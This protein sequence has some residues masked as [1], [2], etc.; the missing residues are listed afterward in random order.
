[1]KSG[2]FAKHSFDSR[3]LWPVLVFVSYFVSA[4]LGLTYALIGQTVTLMWPPSGIAL[5]AILLGGFRIWPSIAL[6][7]L[8]ANVFIEHLTD[9]SVAII[10]VG[11]TLEPMIGAALLKRQQ[12]FSIALDKTSDVLHLLILAASGSTMIGAAFG[13]LALYVNG[14][15]DAHG[16][17]VTCLTWWLGDGMG[18]L[19]VSPLIL[20][21]F[22]KSR[23]VVFWPWS[24]R[25][26]EA[27]IFLL[28]VIVT[29]H[30]LFKRPELA[31]LGYFQTSLSMFPFAIWSALRFGSV[32]AAGT[33]LL[34]SSLAIHGTVNGTGPFALDS[35]LSSLMLWCLFADLIAITGLILAAVDGGRMKALTALKTSN[36]TLD[37]QVKER[38]SELL[39]A[40][41][42]LYA[43][44]EE[45]NRLQFEMN[46]ISEERQKIIG[47]ELHDGLGQQLTG[48][49]FM[50]ASLSEQLKAQTRPEA[51]AMENIGQLLDEALTGLRSL[52]RGLYPTALETGGLCSALQ[53]LA[54]YAQS[55][56]VRCAFNS[57]TDALDID[58]T[59][60]L[61]L[62]RIGQEAVCNAIRH[63]R[64]QYI[65][66]CLLKRNGHYRLTI[67]DDGSGFLET[68]TSQPASLGIRS[69]RS[70]ANLIGAN[71]EFN[72][73]AGGGMSIIVTGPNKPSPAGKLYGR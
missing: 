51:V 54:E 9:V 1:M 59:S 67:A 40:N 3:N 26:L 63:G 15:I 47:Q 44:L 66:I 13:G 49:A 37:K 4:K 56:G 57:N 71:I 38:T 70:R 23:S 29:G 6:G 32:G 50:V 48:I 31:G 64:P 61:N 19:V 53:Y 11:D 20:T 10:T 34:V 7:A 22:S 62:Y 5:A 30:A 58:K 12:D 69:M 65:D 45:R 43:T 28:M 60:A 2:Y 16:I 72:N 52:S 14:E 8:A 39:D 33:A 68:A 21:F 73:N 18:V 35:K 41:L 17:V 42:A 36:E 27:V 46:Q 55:S 24:G 25:T